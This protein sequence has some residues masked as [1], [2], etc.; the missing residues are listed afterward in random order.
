MDKNTEWTPNPSQDKK[1]TEETS[2]GKRK[3]RGGSVASNKKSRKQSELQEA[4]EILSQDY[5]EGDINQNRETATKVTAAL[6]VLCGKTRDSTSAEVNPQ[7]NMGEKDH[8]SAADMRAILD[9]SNAKLTAT[10]QQGVATQIANAV[11]DITGAVK[12]NSASISKLGEEVK[13]IRES[14]DPEKTRMM[15]ERV[16]EERLRAEPARGLVED[17]AQGSGYRSREDSYMKA[18]KSL[19]IWPVPGK[20]T[21]EIWKNTGKYMEEVL[22]VNT[23]GPEDIALIRR[24]SPGRRSRAHDVVMV[25]FNSVA[26]RDSVYRNAPNLASHVDP[27]GNPRAGLML[28]IPYYL[29]GL[30]KTLQ[31]RGHQLRSLHGPGFKRHVRMSD[32]DQSLKLDV[33]FPGDD[34]WQT[35]TSTLAREM[36][37]ID[38][39]DS[40]KKLR[41]RLSQGSDDGVFTHNTGNFRTNPASRA[42]ATPLGQRPGSWSNA[43][44]HSKQSSSNAWRPSSVGEA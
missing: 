12:K 1:I 34:N 7:G 30:F 4:L 36:D 21:E 23:I 5:G 14:T 39:M 8:L 44:E 13:Q 17:L 19:R 28:E 37:D 43:S 9:S 41:S 3:R 35:I 18:R 31:R 29:L 10:L 2:T 22:R 26:D 33:K 16:V 11:A 38:R 25:V 6:D 15:V 24:V 20:N 40:E 27:Q 32:E 42:N